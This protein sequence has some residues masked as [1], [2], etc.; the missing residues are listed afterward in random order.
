MTQEALSA[1]MNLMSHQRHEIHKGFIKLQRLGP[2]EF[3]DQSRWKVRAPESTGM[4]AFPYPHFDVFYAYHRYTDLLPKKYRERYPKDL[5]WYTRDWE[6]E[7]P[8]GNVPV[9]FRKDKYDPRRE[10][11]YYLHEDGTWQEAELRAE[12]HVEREEWIERVGK[13]VLPL[14]EFWY[15]GDLYSH[16]THSGEIGNWTMSSQEEGNEFTLMS[17]HEL[18]KHMRRNGV[19]SYEGYHE[20]DGRPR[21]IRY[22]RDHLEVFIPR[23]R[24]IIRDSRP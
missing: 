6:G 2:I 20:V 13:K 17:T 24:G 22:S 3:G 9:E 1:K 8:L 10:V 5:K 19:V 16:F 11:P 12:Y 21:P 7:I 18:D 23:G 15:K 4:W 14:R